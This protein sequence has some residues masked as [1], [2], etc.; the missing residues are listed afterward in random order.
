MKEAIGLTIPAA[1]LLRAH[2]VIEER[3]LTSWRD[4]D[5]SSPLPTQINDVSHA[6]LHMR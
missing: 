5:C 3:S 1:F 6:A 4:Q 2:E